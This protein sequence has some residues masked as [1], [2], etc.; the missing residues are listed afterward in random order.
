MASLCHANLP[1]EAGGFWESVT[2]K[3]AWELPVDPCPDWVET[4]GLAEVSTRWRM[5]ACRRLQLASI[6]RIRRCRVEPPPDDRLRISVSQLEGLREYTGRALM[7]VIALTNDDAGNVV[8]SGT[9]IDVRGNPYLLTAQHVVRKRFDS[10]EGGEPYTGIGHDT[11]IEGPVFRITN[12]TYG[13]GGLRD[14]AVARLFPEDF[15]G[16]S[17]RPLPIRAIPNRTPDLAGE[18]L[19]VH[20]Y[21]GRKSRFFRA[22]QGI[23]STSFSFIATEESC[24]CSWFDPAVHIAVGYPVEGLG[25]TGRTEDF[26]HPK[27]L[28]GSALWKTNVCA[29]GTVW[30]AADSQIVGVLTDWDQDSRTL[31]AVRIE[32]VWTLL[33]HALQLEGAYFRW[34]DRG[35]P[36]G[37]DWADW[38]AAG[39]DLIGL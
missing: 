22:F 8:G 17:V 4:V 28:S 18:I 25:E 27:G 23:A 35:S 30:S 5:T 33:L 13:Y 38:F 16:T 14:V 1:H 26:P 32:Y 39:R 6:G 31:I 36:H 29:R 3:P 2:A 20:G 21:P 10:A 9:C 19:Y 34:L 37:D 7:R 11:G 24:R 15:A 12:P